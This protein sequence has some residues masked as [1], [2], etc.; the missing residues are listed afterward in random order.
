M[1]SE[2]CNNVSIEPHL[3]PLSGEAICFETMKLEMLAL[4]K[5]K[6][7]QIKRKRQKVR[8]INVCG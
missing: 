6:T 4:E 7:R 1:M 2:V 8:R 5:E 3:Q